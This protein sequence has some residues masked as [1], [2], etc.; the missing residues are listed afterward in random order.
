MDQPLPDQIGTLK[1]A[2]RLPIPRLTSLER[3]TVELRRRRFRAM[4]LTTILN[5]CPRFRG[6]VYQFAHFSADQK[7]IEVAVRPRQGLGRSLLALPFA[8]AGYDQ[9]AERRFEF[10]LLWGFLVFLL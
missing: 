2:R 7:S 3:F 6:F 9:L 4:E 5:R 8:G 1:V 10:I